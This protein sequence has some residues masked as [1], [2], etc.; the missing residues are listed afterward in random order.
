M[1]V[2]KQ[3]KEKYKKTSDSSG[4]P[5]EPI[6]VLQKKLANGEPL[7]N[8]LGTDDIKSITDEVG[9]IEHSKTSLWKS[10]CCQISYFC[11]QDKESRIR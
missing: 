9:K 6:S 5:T 1:P 2:K 3:K 7:T 11:K 8:G 10:L 4:K